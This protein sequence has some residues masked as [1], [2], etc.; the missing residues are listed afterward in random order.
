MNLAVRNADEGRDV[1]AQVQQR[2]QFD[3]GLVLAEPGPREQRQT[4]VDGGRIQAYRLWSR[5]TPIGSRR[6]VAGPCRSG[7]GRSRRRCAS[8]ASRWRRPGCCAPPCR[9]S[10][11]GRACR[12]SSAGTP[13]CRAGSR[14][15]STA[16]S[17]R[18]ETGPS[19]RNSS[20]GNRRDN[21]PHISEIRTKAGGPAAGRKQFGRNSPLIV[22]DGRQ[23]RRA[24]F[25]PHR[26]RKNSNREMQ[27]CRLTRFPP[28]G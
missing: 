14:G 27:K 18:S 7:P 8:R 22:G 6:R 24:G 12:A 23:T 16:R 9:G 10:P 28:N 2:V 3:G 20:A 17:H 25:G 21:G 13:R 5:S 1:A 26:P 19:R 4:Q 15:R 11:R